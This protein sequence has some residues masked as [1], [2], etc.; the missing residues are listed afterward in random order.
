MDP[1]VPV[2]GAWQSAVPTQ[3]A[4]RPAVPAPIIW[5]AARPSQAALWPGSV[6]AVAEGVPHTDAGPAA[7]EAR[8]GAPETA[9]STGMDSEELRKLIGN[10]GDEATPHAKRP[11]DLD[12]PDSLRELADKVYPQL[13]R[14]LRGELLADRERAGLLSELS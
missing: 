4:R 12:D 3:T 7:G 6:A 5:Q 9:A 2:Q 11:A 13:R 8:T 14:L 1:A 10:S